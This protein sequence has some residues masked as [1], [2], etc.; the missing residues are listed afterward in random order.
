MT[1]LSDDP[2]LKSAGY[3]LLQV[4]HKKNPESRFIISEVKLRGFFIVEFYNVT[5]PVSVKELARV[6]PMRTIQVLPISSSTTSI[7]ILISRSETKA[8]GNS[9]NVQDFIF[10]VMATASAACAAI[11]IYRNIV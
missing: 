5:A 2:F 11:L 8:R 7:Q 3:A 6:L 9:I 4:V 1:L 10:K